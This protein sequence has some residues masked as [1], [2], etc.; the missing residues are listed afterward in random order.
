MENKWLDGYKVMSRYGKNYMSA[1]KSKYGFKVYRI[2]HVTAR[3]PGNGPLAVF[4]T[5]TEALEWCDSGIVMRVRYTLSEDKS[6]WV[7]DKN[8]RKE[9][10][11]F[12]ATGSVFA[13]EIESIE[14]DC[15][16]ADGDDSAIIEA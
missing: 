10:C 6:Y 12:Y 13:D 14:L 15:S 5:K 2:G 16:Q 4:G 9:N 7:I 11:G 1:I 8:G 3:T